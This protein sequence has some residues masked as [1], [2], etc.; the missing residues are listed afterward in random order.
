MQK[1]YRLTQESN[2]MRKRNEFEE[3]WEDKRRGDDVGKEY[4]GP[5]GVRLME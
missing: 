5:P 3:D 4:F 2:G 1:G